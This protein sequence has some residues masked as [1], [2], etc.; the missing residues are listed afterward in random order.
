MDDTK[1]RNLCAL[2][3]DE[4]NP[5]KLWDLVDQLNNTLDER[6]RALRGRAT[7]GQSRIV[8]SQ[9]PEDST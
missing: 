3:I 6:E 7:K 4:R 5:D 1:W 2:I 8:N 9:T